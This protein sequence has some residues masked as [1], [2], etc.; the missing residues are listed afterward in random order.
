MENRLLGEEWLSACRE[1][2]KKETKDEVAYIYMRG[3]G[4]GD[5][6]RFLKELERDAVPRR[7]LIFDLRYNSGGNVH[8]R[9]LQA[10][11]K[12]VYAK[13]RRRGLSETPQSTFGFA[14]KPVV[15]ITNEV[16]LSDGEMT[17]NGFK[18]LKRGPIVG[19]TTYGWLIFTGSQRL[20]NGGYFRLPFWGCYTLDGEDLETSGGVEPDV[21]V[22][23][24]LNHELQG[25]DPQLDKAIELILELIK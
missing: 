17:A 13:W 16:T 19:N 3:M 7:G 5:L 22:I 2:V 18:T 14:D 11:T 21:F 6:T 4:R 23:N 10:L 8:D 24:D 20:M 15:L 12:P 25:Q 1:T 9:V